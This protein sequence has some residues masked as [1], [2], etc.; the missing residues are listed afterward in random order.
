MNNC[1]RRRR[2]REL[3]PETAQSTGTT[4]AAESNR[5]GAVLNRQLQK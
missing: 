2:R 4:G 5:Q 1:R 3:E